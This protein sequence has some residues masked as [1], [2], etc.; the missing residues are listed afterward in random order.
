[1]PPVSFEESKITRGKQ[2]LYRKESDT[3]KRMLTI[4]GENSPSEV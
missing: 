4:F 1:L 3:D 2:T